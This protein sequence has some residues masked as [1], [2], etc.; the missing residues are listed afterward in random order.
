L[1]QKTVIM[2]RLSISFTKPN[3]EWLRMQVDNNEYFSKS[4]VV[5]DLIRQARKN[6]GQVDWIRAKLTK[7]ETKGFTNLTQEE[8]LQ[9]SKSLLNEKI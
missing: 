6:Q 3:D 9:Q 1:H 7:S 4:E 8:I 2:T 5:N